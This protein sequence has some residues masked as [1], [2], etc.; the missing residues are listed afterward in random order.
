MGVIYLTTNKINNKKYIGVDSKNNKNYYGSGKAI[1]LALKKYGIE[2][3][4]KEILESND[5]NVYLFER[6]KYWINLYDAINSKQFYNIAIGGKGGAGT[7]I[8]EDSKRRHLESCK[9]GGEKTGTFRK[10]K[11]YEEIYGDRAFDEK[12][13]RR[14]AGLGKKYDESRIKKSAES[15]KGK[16]PWN[17]GKIGTQE[18]WNK[19][20]YSLKHDNTEEIFIGIR[21]LKNKIRSINLSLKRLE[22]IDFSKLIKNKTEKGYEIHSIFLKNSTIF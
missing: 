22:K 15:R 11:S 7:L 13:K 5:D 21:E 12:E 4:T 6:E 16:E 18:A 19:K 3:F 14:L 8:N 17:K 20:I 1:K 2:N 10:G 9:L